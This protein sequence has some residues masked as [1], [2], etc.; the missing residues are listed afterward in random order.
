[1]RTAFAK[2]HPLPANLLPRGLSRAEAATYLGISKSHFDTL[3][4]EGALPQPIH[5]RGRKVWDRVRLDL[6]FGAVP[7]F[8]LTK[9]DPWENPAA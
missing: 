9:D 2:R 8:E 3:V 6:V 1:M 4:R 5:L 7:D